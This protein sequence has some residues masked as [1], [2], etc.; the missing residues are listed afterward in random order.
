MA[1]ARDRTAYFLSRAGRPSRSVG[2]SCGA[3]GAPGRDGPEGLGTPFE[4]THGIAVSTVG[5]LSFPSPDCAAPGSYAPHSGQVTAP[6]SVRL[7][8]LQ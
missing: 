4:W 2:G 7:H 1:A 3:A 6:L 8:G 5:A